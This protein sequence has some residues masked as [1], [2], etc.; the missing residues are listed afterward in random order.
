MR[1]I[2]LRVVLIFIVFPIIMF[3]QH[4]ETDRFR[5]FFLLG[6]S[7]MVGYGNNKDLP[8]SL[9]QEF[10]NV[11]IFHGNPSV[12]NDSLAGLGKW[13]RLKPGHG[14]MFSFDG[15]ENIMSNLFGAELSFAKRMQ[16][17]YPN[18]K[19]AIIKY[20]HGGT[21]IDSIQKVASWDP[22]YNGDKDKMGINQYDFFLRTMQNAY[23]I[24]DID[25]DGHPDRLIPS[26]IVWMQGE[27]DGVHTE[28]VALRYYTNLK[29][30]MDLIRAA[31]HKDDLPVVIGKISDSGMNKEGKMW[32][33]GELVQYAQEKYARIDK[34]AAIVRDTKEYGYS[35]GAHYNSAGYVSLGESFASL[36]Y[37]LIMNKHEKQNI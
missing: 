24:S 4:K 28:E 6:Q 32:K 18:E 25:G 15:H 3:C 2:R 19:I 33:Y 7:N 36:L 10:A 23:A 14:E 37:E 27:S 21:S 13:E 5:A 12:V 34:N 17:L 22:E 11:F 30:L 9:N 20:S 1:D 8:E 35:D 26:G 29:R 31:L 16:E